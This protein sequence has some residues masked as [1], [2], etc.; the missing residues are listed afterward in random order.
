[1]PDAR[2]R[3]R[4]PHRCDLRATPEL[5]AR[6]VAERDRIAPAGEM[7]GAGRWV[8]A[9][10]AGA[11]TNLL[12][13]RPVLPERAAGQGVTGPAPRTIAPRERGEAVVR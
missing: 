6:L 12:T 11:T 7:V 1:M 4:R 5:L 10:I 13:G 2:R 8:D 3:T 9:V